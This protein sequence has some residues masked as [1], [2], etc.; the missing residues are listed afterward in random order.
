[1]TRSCV[2][3]SNIEPHLPPRISRSN[4]APTRSSCGLPTPPRPPMPHPLISRPRSASSAHWPSPPRHSVSASY[5]PHA[6]SAARRSVPPSTR[7]PPLGACSNP[8]PVTPLSDSR[9]HRFRF[10]VSRS[11]TP[12]GKRKRETLRVP[13]FSCSASHQ[14]AGSR[15]LSDKSGTATR[16]RALTSQSP[17][18]GIVL[19][20]TGKFIEWKIEDWDPC[21]NP[22]IEE[23]S[24]R[25][26]RYGWPD[27]GHGVSI[28]SSRN[29]PVGRADK[30]QQTQ[31][32]KESQS[33]HRGIVL[34]DFRVYHGWLVWSASQSPH[35][36][37]VLS[38][39]T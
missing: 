31:D 20:D 26:S 29:R 10:P 35:R 39:L 19:S 21:L 7:S 4:S 37:I 17:H 28:P 3:V 9:C 25:T 22:L 18:R 14:K 33:P 32:G 13:Q 12:G 38:D 8:L 1:V 27:T 24:C 36:G 15:S 30:K 5:A 2:S 16:R 23:S 6:A 34:S 11:P